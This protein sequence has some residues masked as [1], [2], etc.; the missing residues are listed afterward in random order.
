MS[1]NNPLV[2]AFLSN[3]FDGVFVFDKSLV[4]QYHNP[5][6]VDIFSFPSQS[7]VGQPIAYLF[8]FIEN[9]ES[10]LLEVLS[11]QKIQ[12]KNQIYP[13]SHLEDKVFF[14]MNFAPIR[15]PQGNIEQ[16]LVI[17][18]D[19]TEI[20]TK[21][22]NKKRLKDALKAFDF[23]N[24]RLKCIINGTSDLIVAVDTQFHFI[25]F[26]ERFKSNFERYCGKKINLGVSILDCLKDLP[27]DY[28]KTKENWERV[29][30]GEDFYQVD[31]I[32]ISEDE[33]AFLESNYNL[34][35][36]RD[37]HIIGATQI[38]R[39]ITERMQTEDLWIS[40]EKR[41][42]KM[43]NEANV[44][45]A[46]IDVETQKFVHVNPSLCQILAY[47]PEELYAL[48]L[49]DISLPDDYEKED[50]QI[51]R[52]K[53]T[54]AISYKL[55]KRVFNK[56]KE[57]L[58]V[59]VAG[60]L[61]NDAHENP[62]FILLVIENVTHRIIAQKRLYESEAHNRALVNALPDMIFNLD[63]DANILFCK[64]GTLQFPLNEDDVMGKNLDDILLPQKLKR[65]IKKTIQETLNGETVQ[66]YEG[67]LWIENRLLIYEARYVKTGLSQVVAIVRD[68]TRRRKEE[69]RIKELLENE[70]VLSDYLE[71]QNEKLAVQEEQIR[72]AYQNLLIQKD[73]LA[74][75][76]KELR[77]SRE[78]LKQALKTL[79]ERNFELDQFVYKTSHDLRSPLTSILGIINLIK[80]DPDTTRHQE[81]VD[82]IQTRILRL[83]EFIQSMLH[84]SRNTRSELLIEKINFEEIF[85]ETLDDLQYAKNF[86]NVHVEW[87]I[88]AD[89]IDFYSDLLRLKIITNNVISNAIKYQ[90]TSKEERFIKITV[91]INPE[92]AIIYFKDNGIGI[93][94]KYLPEIYKMFYRATES[95]E[96][97]GLGLYIVKQTVEKL[98]GNIEIYSEGNRKGL[99]VRVDVP[100]HSPKKIEIL[101]D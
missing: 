44:G 87:L 29:F 82:K 13:A 89:N 91:E 60:T 17:I 96:G 22:M 74:V 98:R 77:K 23:S 94:K 8:P 20:K 32:D 47:Q 42:S 78:N 26:N 4:I 40:S 49:K 86:E 54:V 93:E 67:E 75:T 51:S 16:G 72:E 7:L 65:R 85:Q 19:I 52:L 66:I 27:E 25:L 39:D 56:H 64:F 101:S 10:L 100:N 59:S 28:Q 69:A 76:T 33:V 88:Q 43:F 61:L 99:W 81:Y 21:A 80:M 5:I 50:K 14:D 57:E 38:I 36:D 2:E 46:L 95:E 9:C 79:E 68:I 71:E 63:K 24:D 15:N 6:L 1:E 37:G 53:R 35:Y 3:S 83:D 58:W 97:S 73:S 62:E 30:S 31:Q 18:K 92:K 55:D 45:L 41:F 48:S 70:R 34:V 90:D 12:L 11:G 84:Y